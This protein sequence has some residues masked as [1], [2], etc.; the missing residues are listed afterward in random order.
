MVGVSLGNPEMLWKYCQTRNQVTLREV[1]ELRF[2]F[3][4]MPAVPDELVL[5]KKKK[6]VLKKKKVGIGSKGFIA[7]SLFAKEDKE[8]WEWMIIC[9][10]PFILAPDLFYGL[11]S[12]SSCPITCSEAIFCSI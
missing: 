3:Y 11:T 12:N 10:G 9:M 4:F 8:R 6:K 7:G 1:G 2:L 5:K